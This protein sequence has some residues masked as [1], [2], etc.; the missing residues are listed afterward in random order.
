MW[1]P[2]SILT[3]FSILSFVFLPTCLNSFEEP[4]WSR[5]MKTSKQFILWKCLTCHQL[6]PML[7][8][9]EPINLSSQFISC[10]VFG[11]F[12][13]N[14]RWLL[15]VHL[16]RECLRHGTASPANV[17]V[18]EENPRLTLPPSGPVLRWC[19][20]WTAC[21]VL[22][23]LSAD[24][25]ALVQSV[26]CW[27]GFFSELMLSLSLVAHSG[28]HFG[29]TA[30]N[31]LSLSFKLNSTASFRALLYMCECDREEPHLYVDAH[32]WVH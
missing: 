11:G 30:V 20:E 5:G 21:Q 4:S 2:I 26:A 29:E 3:S 25:T 18:K 6:L 14:E 31:L 32:A 16:R 27:P 17:T 13:C 24:V 1:I 8:H 9:V 12:A 7:T 28:H 15:C 10:L 23:H 19:V 22:W